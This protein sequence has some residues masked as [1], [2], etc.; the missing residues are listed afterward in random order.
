MSVDQHGI[1]I[2]VGKLFLLTNISK[3]VVISFQDWN[4]GRYA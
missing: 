4:F 3:L 2:S 1:S